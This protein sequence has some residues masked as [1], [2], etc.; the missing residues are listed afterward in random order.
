MIVYFLYIIIEIARAF[1]YSS[2]VRHASE[3]QLQADVMSSGPE[4][5]DMF[6][7]PLP[8][9]SDLVNTFF[10]ELDD[11][12]TER[13]TPQ[14]LRQRKKRVLSAYG[15]TRDAPPGLPKWALKV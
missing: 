7:K 8:W 6:V 4:E 1:I 13:K 14:A 10:A 5:N 2:K 9:R 12:S 15:S 11:R 3:N